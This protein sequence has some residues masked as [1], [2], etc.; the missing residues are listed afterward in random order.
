[1]S[2]PPTS[3]PPSAVGRPQHALQVVDGASAGT[4]AHVR[5]LTEGLVARGLRVTVCAPPG[6][7]AVYGFRGAGAHFAPLPAQ[8]EPEAAAVL[9]RL[10]AD[11]DLVHAHGV[12][13]GLLALTT[14]ALS[15][16]ARRVPLVVTWHHRGHASGARAQVRRL[17]ERRV[18]RSASVVL[19]VT[20]DLVDRARRRGARD[21]RLAPVVLPGPGRD[22]TP[23]EPRA[24]VESRGRHKSRAEVGAVGRPLVLSVG[25]LDD[26]HG[27][28]T[29]LTAARAWRHL[30]PQPLLAVAGEGPQ[31]TELQ[32][33]IDDEGL[34]VRLLGRREDAFELLAG[35]DVALLNSRWEGRPLLAQEALHEGV[36]LVATAVG[37]VP[38]LVGQ[39]AELI[40]FGDPAALAAA[41]AGLLA[42]PVR[43]ERF[44]AEGWA[45]AAEWPSEEATVAHVLSVY[46]ELACEGRP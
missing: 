17:I 30:D 22:E 1:M 14:L 10:C 39:A 13:A 29:A 19:A 43:R 5:S 7:E 8:S 11:A 36:P 35:A 15:G 16:R 37:G 21:A 18:A 32:R 34:P 12:R 28:G 26:R 45:R 23:L 33:R 9:R 6:A 3:P 46:D 27:Y 4:G 24:A 42:D 44:A 25:R 38:E 2:L 20:T 31:R 40:P 41:V